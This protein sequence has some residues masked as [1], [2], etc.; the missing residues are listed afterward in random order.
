[1]KK[2]LVINANPK[3][4]SFCRSLANSYALSAALEHEVKQLHI[5]EM[6][7]A[8]SLDHGFDDTI[9]LE[10]DLLR[11]QELILWAEHIVIVTPVWWGSLPAKFKGLVD[12]VFL[13]NFAFKYV[14]GKSFPEKLLSGR[15]SELMI[16]LDTPPFWYKYFNGNVIYK[17][18]K[19]TILDF[20]GIK[21]RSATYFG[22]IASSSAKTRA[23]WLNKASKLA[24]RI[25]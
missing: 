19:N 14:K 9:A 5:S 23:F 21:N 7:F 12:R 24:S 11:F 18:V 2:V 6:S 8:I 13:P 22:P 10:P 20:S 4:E 1:M 25:K 3:R 15:T 16:T 17:H